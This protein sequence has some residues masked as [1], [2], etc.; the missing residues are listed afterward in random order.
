[1]LTKKHLFQVFVI[2]LSLIIL[3]FFS[4]AYISPITTSATFECRVVKSCNECN[5]GL[6]GYEECVEKGCAAEKLCCKVKDIR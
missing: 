4:L 5:Q 6:I 3:F 1:M 2:L